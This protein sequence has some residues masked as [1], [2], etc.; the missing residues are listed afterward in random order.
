M[1][2]PCK[3][4]LIQSEFIWHLSVLSDTELCLTLIMNIVSP[5]RRSSLPGRQIGMMLSANLHQSE[6]S[7][8]SWP[9]VHQSQ[10][11]WPSS[12]SWPARGRSRRWRSC[13]WGGPPCAPPAANQRW[14]L[15]GHVTT[16][17]PITAHLPLHVLVGLRGAREVPLSHPDAD[18]WDHQT[19]TY[20]CWN[21]FVGLPKN[22]WIK[23]F[24][25][26]SL[27]V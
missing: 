1:R 22:I 12:P 25:N 9:A 7:I 26:F 4:K 24:G 5:M 13:T 3:V 11:T 2:L 27:T 18:L 17:P 23:I 6:M 20:L 14:A 16:S 8:C 21:S 15:Q 19:E 10:L